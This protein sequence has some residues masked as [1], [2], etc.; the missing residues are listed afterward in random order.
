MEQ[1]ARGN[2]EILESIGKLVKE[3]P[4]IKEARE[5]MERTFQEAGGVAW[6]IP[7][8]KI[9]E[10]AKYA[11]ACL[12]EA[13]RNPEIGIKGPLKVFLKDIIDIQNRT[14]E[15]GGAKVV[16]DWKKE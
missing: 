14:I 13:E 3:I 6:K 12:D 10:A 9:E 5:I 7:E 8:E 4:P 2:E 1:E 15:K 11:K 16:E